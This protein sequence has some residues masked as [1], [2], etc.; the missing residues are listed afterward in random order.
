MASIQPD[1]HPVEEV[2]KLGRLYVTNKTPRYE[3]PPL[4]RPSSV[5]I[6]P[7]GSAS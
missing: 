6:S 7:S 4:I 2:D 1:D 5:A 3:I